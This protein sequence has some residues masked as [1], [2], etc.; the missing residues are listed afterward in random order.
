MVIGSE[1]SRAN[2]SSCPGKTPCTTPPR[3]VTAVRDLIYTLSTCY[4]RNKLFL[5][6]FSPI[7]RL[8]CEESEIFVGVK[9]DGVVIVKIVGETGDIVARRWG[10]AVACEVSKS[11]TIVAACLLRAA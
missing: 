10:R 8:K 11:A 9:D 4:L 7:V 3:G 6:I 5:R 1:V 2:T